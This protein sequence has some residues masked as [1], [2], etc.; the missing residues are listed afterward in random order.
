MALTPIEILF[1]RSVNQAISVAIDSLVETGTEITITNITNQLNKMKYAGKENWATEFLE[2][3]IVN[4]RGNLNSAIIG[5]LMA[6][7]IV[8]IQGENFA[9]FQYDNIKS[10]VSGLWSKFENALGV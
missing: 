9:I 2:S 3:Y 10:G 7:R 8:R 4:L 6:S 1:E 5:N